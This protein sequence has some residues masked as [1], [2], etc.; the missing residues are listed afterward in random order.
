MH[1]IERF[2]MNRCCIKKSE[3][4]D[5]DC[6]HPPIKSNARSVTFLWHRDW[7]PASNLLISLFWWLQIYTVSLNCPLQPDPPP[8]PVE[9]QQLATLATQHDNTKINGLTYNN[10]VNQHKTW[11]NLQ[12]PSFKMGHGWS[13]LEPVWLLALGEKALSGV[14]CTH[15]FQF[16]YCFADISV[17]F[18]SNK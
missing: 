15:I 16:S 8:Q 7:W 1:N 10:K 5:F 9:L 17:T 18:T 14:K 2:N 6:K 13:I 3:K 12:L 11:P 4:N